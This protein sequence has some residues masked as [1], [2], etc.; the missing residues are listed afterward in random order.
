MSANLQ[1]EFGYTLVNIGWKHRD[2]HVARLNRRGQIGPVQF[3]GGGGTIT[4]RDLG[5]GQGPVP[6]NEGTV[7]CSESPYTGDRG[8]SGAKPMYGGH[9]MIPYFCG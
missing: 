2:N 6:K 4:E 5:F 9:K 7:G 1:T 3:P 8:E